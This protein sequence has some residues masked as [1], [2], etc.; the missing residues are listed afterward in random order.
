MEVAHN[1]GVMMKRRLTK[2]YHRSSAHLTPSAV[3]TELMDMVGPVLAKHVKRYWSDVVLDVRQFDAEVADM[4]MPAPGDVHSRHREFAY[5][6][7]DCGT[8]LYDKDTKDGLDGLNAC[9]TTFGTNN[10]RC[11]ILLISKLDTS[12]PTGVVFEIHFTI[13]SIPKRVP[14]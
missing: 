3:V 7:R 13:N 14:A 5:I 10:V 4:M 1:D 12:D 8:H 9:N 6:I 2:G 11:E